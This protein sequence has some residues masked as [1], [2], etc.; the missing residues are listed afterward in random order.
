MSEDS[1]TGDDEPSGMNEG[2]PRLLRCTACQEPCNSFAL[3]LHPLL[4]TAVCG[5]CGEK[6]GEPLEEDEDGSYALC[7]WCRDEGTLYCCDKCV[8][9]A[10]VDACVL[11]QPPLTM[12]QLLMFYQ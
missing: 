3:A 7:S 11:F 8:T 4:G 9:V 2:A 1:V 12:P 10:G 6:L 5:E